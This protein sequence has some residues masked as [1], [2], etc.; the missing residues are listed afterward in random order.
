MVSPM[1][2]RGPAPFKALLEAPDRISPPRLDEVEQ[3][4]MVCDASLTLATRQAN[5]PRSP[6]MSFS[7]RQRTSRLKNEWR[8]ALV[9]EGRRR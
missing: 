6:T 4:A 3:L 5:G 7:L 1:P 2:W 8:L 9:N